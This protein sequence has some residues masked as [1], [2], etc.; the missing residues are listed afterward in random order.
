MVKADNRPDAVRPEP[1][2]KL[3]EDERTQIISLCNQPEFASLPPSQIVPTLLD[4]GIYVAS[5]SS[6]YRVLKQ[7]NQLHHRV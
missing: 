2:N 1:K 7:A 4:D 3:T 6:F 5:T